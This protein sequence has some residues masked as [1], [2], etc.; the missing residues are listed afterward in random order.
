MSNQQYVAG[1]VGG[2][3]T[4]LV[5]LTG[6]HFYW[7][8]ESEATLD[9][10]RPIAHEV[11]EPFIFNN[12]LELEESTP[13][14][15]RDEQIPTD[16]MYFVLDYVW[17]FLFTTIFVHV[18]VSPS[19]N[20]ITRKLRRICAGRKNVS[21]E[22]SNI[23]SSYLLVRTKAKYWSSY[24]LMMLSLI[25]GV[26]CYMVMCIPSFSYESLVQDP[27]QVIPLLQETWQVYLEYIPSI[28]FIIYLLLFPEIVIPPIGK[29]ISVILS[30]PSR[31]KKTIIYTESTST[32][33]ILTAPP[34]NIVFPLLS[35]NMEK[36]RADEALAVAL[37]DDII[38]AIVDTPVDHVDISPTASV[39]SV[40]KSCGI[41]ESHNSP[42]P[43]SP[44]TSESQVNTVPALDKKSLDRPISN[45]PD[46]EEESQ[47]KQHPSPAPSATSD[48][49]L[50]ETENNF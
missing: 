40:S 33:P 6:H 34:E 17:M 4:I 50:A 19:L 3:A 20:A 27:I 47:S 7:N 48:A 39:Q 38:Q 30:T 28:I 44:G 16:P 13:A 8:H 14:I 9:D 5:T 32:T 12:E 35:E 36:H 46:V 43:R 21:S 37:V 18:F 45:T 26:Q 15:T 42:P 10:L 1:S 2:M 23:E 11:E 22:V 29:S 49:P 25:W 24:M 31:L 41:S